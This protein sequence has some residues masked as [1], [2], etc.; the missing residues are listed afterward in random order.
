MN[1]A[2]A[3]PHTLTPAAEPGGSQLAPI[4]AYHPQGERRLPVQLIDESAGEESFLQKRT[5]ERPTP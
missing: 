1:T 5:N 2:G 3:S 4:T